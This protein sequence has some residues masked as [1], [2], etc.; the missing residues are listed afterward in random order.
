LEDAANVLVGHAQNEYPDEIVDLLGE[1]AIRI[2][3]LEYL[4][5]EM[6]GM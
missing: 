3:K 1:A 5:D 6:E 2:R 4:L